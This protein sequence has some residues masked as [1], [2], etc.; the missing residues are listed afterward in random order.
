M[1]EYSATFVSNNETASLIAF[2]DSPS[3]DIFHI[4]CAFHFSFANQILSKPG[5]LELTRILYNGTIISD[6]N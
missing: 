1:L 4:P 3:I 5:V 2:R 6:R